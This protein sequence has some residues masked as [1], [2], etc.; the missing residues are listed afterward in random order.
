VWV[1]AAAAAAAAAVAV[2]AAA[3]AAAAA[4][5]SAA[6]PEGG[7]AVAVAALAAPAHRWAA[8]TLRRLRRPTRPSRQRRPLPFPAACCDRPRPPS[9]RHQRRGAA[10][11]GARRRLTAVAATGMAERPPRP[12]RLDDPAGQSERQ[13][14]ASHCRHEGWPPPGSRWC[15]PGRWQPRATAAPAPSLAAD[16]RR[17]PSSRFD[18]ACASG[19]TRPTGPTTCRRPTPATTEPPPRRVANRPT[20]RRG[21]TP[22]AAT[23]ASSTTTR[24]TRTAIFCLGRAAPLRPRPRATRTRACRRPPFAAPRRCCPCGRRRGLPLGGGQRTPTGP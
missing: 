13:P 17:R 14:L 7:V 8:A 2:T 24:S 23:A 21:G 1:A 18:G 11:P 10:A 20:A 22:A 3:A 4:S 5:A 19:C 6:W 15:R 9:P 16:P 12:T